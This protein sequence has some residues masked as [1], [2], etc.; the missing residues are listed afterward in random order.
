[1]QNYCYIVNCVLFLYGMKL[2][3]LHTKCNVEYNVPITYS[4]CVLPMHKLPR[5]HN[6]AIM[7]EVV[8]SLLFPAD[9]RIMDKNEEAC[10]EV[11]LAYEGGRC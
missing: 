11:G 7:G 6:K 8:A 3:T 1:M 10:K 9:L 5:Y 4:M 2:Y